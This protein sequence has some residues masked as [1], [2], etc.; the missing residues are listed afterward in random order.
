MFNSVGL[1]SASLARTGIASF[2]SLE[3]R[4][5]AFSSQGDFV[6]YLDTTTDPAGELANVRFL[7]DELAGAPDLASRLAQE[8]VKIEYDSPADRNA[9]DPGYLVAR[10]RFLNGL[11]TLIA[12]HRAH[13][14]SALMFPPVRAGTFDT[15]ADSWHGT[16]GL[17]ELPGPSLFKVAAHE[18]KNVVGP[19]EH[20]I[21]DDRDA[22]TDFV[23]S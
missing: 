6:T 19:M 2:R 12:E 5:S 21:D 18:L 7:R 20:Q 9:N 13:P 14:G 3:A 16:L 10:K 8:P 22:M 17:A 15:V 23:K 4:T 11:D 1:N